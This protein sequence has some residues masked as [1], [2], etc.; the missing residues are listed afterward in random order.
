MKFN[1]F[2]FFFD[3]FYEDLYVLVVVDGIGGGVFGGFVSCLVLEVGWVLGGDEINWLF[4]FMLNEVCD[5]F[6]KIE[7]YLLFIYK[8]L[9]CEFK[10]YLEL[11]GMGMI[12][13]GVYVVG[14]DVFI[15]YVGDLC[16]FLI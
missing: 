15:I 4:C 1:F 13:I 3:L 8:V 16:V 6:V 9:I 10:V 7:I 5:L 12:F 14:C 11:E 2:V